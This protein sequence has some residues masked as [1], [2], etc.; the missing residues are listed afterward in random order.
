[1]MLVVAS[2]AKRS[3]QMRLLRRFASRNDK[4]SIFFMNY[5]FLQTYVTLPN[6]HPPAS[7]IHL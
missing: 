2:T 3:L 7:G 5:S 4:L 1:M 6:L